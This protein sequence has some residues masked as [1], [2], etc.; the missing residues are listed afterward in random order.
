[1]AFLFVGAIINRPPSKQRATASRPYT[2]SINPINHHINYNLQENLFKILAKMNIKLY[3][4][5]DFKISSCME[6]M[7]DKKL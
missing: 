5:S 6:S 2:I 1:M 3:N 7:F 4:N